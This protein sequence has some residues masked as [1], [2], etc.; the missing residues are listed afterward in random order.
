MSDGQTL[1]NDVGVFVV[2]Y[3]DDAGLEI[4]RE[5]DMSNC[6]VSI[7][8]PHGRGNSSCLAIS[9][10]VLRTNGVNGSLQYDGC[11]FSNGEDN[12]CGDDSSNSINSEVVN[13]EED[14]NDGEQRE[15]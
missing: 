4:Q 2:S 14:D 8:G 15:R 11:W 13:N 5:K 3:L 6:D 7:L 12:S 10:L 1:L 9:S